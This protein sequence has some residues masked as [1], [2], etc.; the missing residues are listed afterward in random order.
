MN[1]IKTIILIPIAA[2]LF[3]LSACN[4]ESLVQSSVIKGSLQQFDGL[5]VIIKSTS[6][7]VLKTDTLNFD[8]SGTFSYNIDIDKPAYYTIQISEAS[9][10]ENASVLIYVRPGDSVIFSGHNTT[11][12]KNT[13]EF[14]GDAPI[15]NDFLHRSVKISTDFKRNIMSVLGRNEETAMAVLDSIRGLHA[16]ELAGLQNSNSNIDEYF[17]KIE[18]ARALYEWAIYHNLY[19]DY[20]EYI[21]KGIKLTTSP[22]FD[23]YLAETN[24]NN[25]ELINLPLYISFVERYIGKQYSAYNDKTT[26]NKYPSFAYYQIET[27]DKTIENQK[28]KNILLHKSISQQVQYEGIKDYDTYWDLLVEKCTNKD[29]IADI[30]SSLSAWQHLKKGEPIAEVEMTDTTGNK[31]QFADFKGKWI[32]IDVWATWCNPCIAEIPVLKELEEKFREQDIVFMSI[33]VDTKQE[34]WKK[35]VIE[36]E[37]KGVQVWA[38]QNAILK[39]FYK[40]YGIPRFMIFDPEG[41]IYQASAERP[42]MDA[43]KIIT[44]LLK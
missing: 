6:P 19:P 10:Q 27:I 37:L 21:N 22:E 14:N 33:S 43:E 32:Y 29:F 15:Y 44:E 1:L 18:K 12:L 4:N 40:V 38:G 13:I 17:L 36:K 41:N 8:Q 3:S 9:T 25:E 23:T 16:T 42:S 30:T 24:I 31:V 39:D 35:M 26:R 34:P 20:Y 28:I 7:Y 2:I 11:D 5:S